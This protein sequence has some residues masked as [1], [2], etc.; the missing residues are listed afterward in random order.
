MAIWTREQTILA[1][2][3]YCETPFGQI[4]GK[5]QDI[6]NLASKIGRSPAALAMK[7][8]NLASFD[9]LIINSGRSGLNHSS[10]LDKEIVE[11]FEQNW[12]RLVDYSESILAQLSTEQAPLKVKIPDYSE[13]DLDKATEIEKIT[14]IRQNQHFF[15][16]VVLTI[17][18]QKCC[19]S[20]LADKRMLI[21]S[22]IIPWNQD[23]KNRLNPRNGLCLSA[24]HDKA[25]D[26]GILTV[27]PD[28]KVQVSPSLKR[29]LPNAFLE[30]S[31]LAMHNQKII[32]PEKFLPSKEFLEFHNQNIF[33]SN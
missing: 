28:L 24:L 3:L 8:A 23:S 17:Y 7:M 20:G 29:F 12:D 27:T 5:N 4:H 6:I 21:A 33:I 11:E 19:M 30:S 32:Q 15:R 26:K 9:P 25:F 1:Y 18:D 10:K 13:L 14:K 2:R 22:H 16:K 31:L